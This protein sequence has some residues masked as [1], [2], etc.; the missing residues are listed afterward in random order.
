M[1]SWAVR[2]VLVDIRLLAVEMVRFER[3][4]RNAAAEGKFDQVAE[5]EK[6]RDLACERRSEL[7][8]EVWGR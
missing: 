4:M 8:R 5:L 3:F 7:L 1:N 2:E 6:Q